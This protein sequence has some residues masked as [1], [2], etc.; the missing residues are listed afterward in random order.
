[1]DADGLRTAFIK[2]QLKRALKYRHT[3]W[4]T[5]AARELGRYIRWFADSIPQPEKETIAMQLSKLEREVSKC[6]DPSFADQP[7]QPTQTASTAT[8]NNA[9]H[10]LKQQ[11][12]KA[13]MS[14]KTLSTPAHNGKIPTKDS[15]VILK[16][17]VKADDEKRAVEDKA[18][19]TARTGNV[20]SVGPNTSKS[21]SAQKGK[22]NFI[23][24]K[25]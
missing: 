7:N 20:T 22:S 21:K 11:I 4:A 8:Q 15:A 9:D 5:R 1:M 10:E 24:I 25:E 23:V 18:S 3:S 6:E 19:S 13:I 17:Q 2:Q 16:G 12:R 14:D